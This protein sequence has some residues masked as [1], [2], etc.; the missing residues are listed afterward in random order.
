[1]R[2]EDEC[3]SVMGRTSRKDLLLSCMHVSLVL[4]SCV[5]RSLD[6][7]AGFGSCV[8]RL[9]FCAILLQ[10]CVGMQLVRNLF[11]RVVQDRCVYV[12]QE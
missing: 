2:T 10:S 12:V 9:H 7:V 1:M 11:E 4:R 8:R 6:F 5:G 3:F